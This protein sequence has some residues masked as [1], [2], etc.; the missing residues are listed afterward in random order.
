MPPPPACLPA[1]I[2]WLSTSNDDVLIVSDLPAV[3]PDTRDTVIEIDL[4]GGPAALP[5]SYVF[6]AGEARY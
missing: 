4:H 2:R 5:G 1:A 3:P 6:W